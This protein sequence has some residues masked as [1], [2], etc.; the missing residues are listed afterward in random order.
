MNVDFVIA[1]QL[2]KNYPLLLLRQLDPRMFSIGSWYYNLVASMK[3][4]PIAKL[5]E[6]CCEVLTL[7]NWVGSHN[8]KKMLNRL[9]MGV[10]N[11]LKHEVTMVVIKT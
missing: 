5:Q 11:A 1:F 6:H 2:T 3:L 7:S 10:T 9:L 4:S 8:P